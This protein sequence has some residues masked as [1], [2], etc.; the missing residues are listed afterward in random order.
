M[1]RTGK[2]GRKQQSKSAEHLRTHYVP[3]AV[4][5]AFTGAILLYL[6]NSQGCEQQKE[7]R[8]ED[9]GLNPYVLTLG[10]FC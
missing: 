6:H 5:S 2:V 7:Q 3:G 9:T 8:R 10:S 4:H 1:L